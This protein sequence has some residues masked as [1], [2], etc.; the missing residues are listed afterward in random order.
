MYRSA[1]LLALTSALLAQPSRA[2]ADTL[3]VWIPVTIASASVFTGSPQPVSKIVIADTFST[4][5][6]LF[7]KSDASA[8]PAFASAFSSA[9]GSL[10]G[11][12]FHTSQSSGRGDA[13]LNGLARGLYRI[14]FSY[15]V[16]STGPGEFASNHAGVGYEFGSTAF[17]LEGTGSGAHTADVA[18]ANGTGPDDNWIAFFAWSQSSGIE[19]TG[20]GTASISD[21]TVT[22]LPGQPGLVPLPAALW[23]FVPAMG[24]LAGAVRRRV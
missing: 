4:V 1:L 10:T 11:A 17:E 13:A 3:P 12:L 24:A 15:T 7:A 2:T 14:S 18:L 23:L 21:I 16:V 19:G 20:S 8:G 22:R 6:L 5:D 9:E